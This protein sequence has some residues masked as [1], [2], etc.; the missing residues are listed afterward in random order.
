MMALNMEIIT[1]SGTF[2]YTAQFNS[3]F[4]IRAMTTPASLSCGANEEIRMW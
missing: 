4:S 1:I 3:H 2:S